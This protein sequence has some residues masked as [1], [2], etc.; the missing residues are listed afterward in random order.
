[1]KFPYRRFRVE[2]FD[3]EPLTEIYR[4][5]VPLLVHGPEGTAL[6]HALLDCGA[7]Y[8]VLPL[9]VA[10]AVCIELD[11]GR[12]GTIGGIEGGSLLTYPGDTELELSDRIESFRWHTT[13]RFAEGNN[14]LLGHLG[15]LEFFR[16]TL[17][18]FGRVVEFL[19]NAAFPGST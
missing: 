9:A 12:P 1:M 5:I 18:H 7:D 2:L 14:M 13:V 16:A 6:V 11:R 10:S 8:T 3:G 17:D 4:P 15:C 19:P